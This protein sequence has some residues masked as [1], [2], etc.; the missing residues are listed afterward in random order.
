MGRLDKSQ[1]L[2]SS[3]IAQKKKTASPMPVKGKASEL[4]ASGA[5]RP[6]FASRDATW[7]LQLHFSS[8][9]A[10][11]EFLLSDPSPDKTKRRVAQARFVAWVLMLG[12]PGSAF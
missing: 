11:S 5:T 10:R 12:A 9:S 1:T 4:S 3:H 6:R 8:L 2:P 7:V